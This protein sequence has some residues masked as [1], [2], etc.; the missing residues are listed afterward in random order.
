M[1]LQDEDAFMQA[2]NLTPLLSKLKYFCHLVILYESLVY[3]DS[4]NLGEDAIG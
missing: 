1:A 4:T 2:S 3:H